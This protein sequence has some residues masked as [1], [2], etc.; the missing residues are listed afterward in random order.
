MFSTMKLD[1][2]TPENL[3]LEKKYFIRRLGRLYVCTKCISMC[4]HNYFSL[5][6]E[7]DII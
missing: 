4:L 2:L 5:V 7:E 1:L 3:N 6:S